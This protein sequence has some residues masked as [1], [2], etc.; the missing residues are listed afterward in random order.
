MLK[1]FLL[2]GIAA[3]MALSAS[4]ALPS[5]QL[6]DVNGKTVDTAELSNDGKP[7][8]ISF[9]S[10]KCKPCIRELTAIMEVYDEWQEQTG[11]RVIIVSTDEAQDVQKVK[12]L[13]ERKGWEFETLLDPSWEFK[14]QMGVNE[15]PHAFIVDGE[16]NIVWNHQGY[17]DGGED[18][19]LDEL[20]K[21]TK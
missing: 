21:L 5:V 1:K 3:L 2:T 17:I 11:T 15:I 16:G 12:P 20:L 9:F 7:F 4:A 13:V 8:V 6:K 14:R 19:I 10:T 18:D